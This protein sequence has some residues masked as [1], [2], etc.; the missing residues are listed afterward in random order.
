[1][2]LLRENILHIFRAIVLYNLWYEST[3]MP[4]FC[5]SVVIATVVLNLHIC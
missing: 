1:M 2:Q 5:F 3:A 4:M